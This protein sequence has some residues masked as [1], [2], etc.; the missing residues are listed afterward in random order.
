MRKIILSDEAERQ[1][2]AIKSYSL[3]QWGEKQTESYLHQIRDTLVRAARKTI[4]GHHHP[5]C[6]K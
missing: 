2:L 6:T 1:I 4:P 5:F 3:S